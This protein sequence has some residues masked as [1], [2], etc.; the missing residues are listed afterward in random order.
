MILAM[1]ALASQSIWLQVYQQ[2][3]QDTKGLVWFLINRF[4][5][6][7]AFARIRSD[8]FVHTRGWGSL[9]PSGQEAFYSPY[10]AGN[11]TEAPPTDRLIGQYEIT[12]PDL[13]TQE[14][15]PKRY[16]RQPHLIH[17]AHPHFKG[18]KDF[19]FIKGHCPY[20]KRLGL[21]FCPNQPDWAV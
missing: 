16:C 3:G 17:V 12:S 11:A 13:T 5:Y 8:V 18:E 1:D 14:P 10:E 9:V 2:G 4:N 20:P 19:Q 7:T 15:P 21:F 6:R